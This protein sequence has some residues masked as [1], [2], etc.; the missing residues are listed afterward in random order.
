MIGIAQ[1]Y[2]QDQTVSYLQLPNKLWFM[3][4][5]LNFSS[6]F[7]FIKESFIKAVS[8]NGQFFAYCENNNNKTTIFI[9]YYNITNGVLYRYE[10]IFQLPKYEKYKNLE[11]KYQ[12]RIINMTFSYDNK[13]YIYV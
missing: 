3:C 1:S 12:S 7:D 8:K 13:L 10:N 9:W 5:R 4:N 6:D 2:V 11:T